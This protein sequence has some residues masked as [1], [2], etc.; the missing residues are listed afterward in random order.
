M[1]D[2]PVPGRGEP[3][4]PHG[5]DLPPGASLGRRIWHHV[6]VG[7]MY[8][9]FGLTTAPVLYEVPGPPSEESEPRP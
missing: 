6:I 8:T 9:G 1:P 2:A 7:L 5:F 4:F 3:G